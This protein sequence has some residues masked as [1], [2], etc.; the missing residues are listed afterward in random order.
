M[1]YVGNN[2]FRQLSNDTIN[3]IKTMLKETHKKPWALKC[4]YGPTMI[5]IAESAAKE[6]YCS[7]LHNMH[8]M[9]KARATS[10]YL[11]AWLL[12]HRAELE[13][14]GLQHR[15]THNTDSEIRT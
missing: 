12:V 11:E 1:K 4:T 6:D 14:I 3:D 7:R 8:R 9:V 5:A 10:E 13:E 2:P 15:H